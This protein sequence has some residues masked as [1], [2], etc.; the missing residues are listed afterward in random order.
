L[1]A[2][3]P[4][5][6]GLKDQLR[7]SF[8]MATKLYRAYSTTKGYHEALIGLEE[9]ESWWLSIVP[10]GSNWDP[11]EGDKKSDL[12]VPAPHSRKKKVHCQADQESAPKNY[13]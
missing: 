6:H 13:F 2:F 10:Q 8:E 12:E 4:Q 5:L 1:L 11:M 7:K 9:D 3:I